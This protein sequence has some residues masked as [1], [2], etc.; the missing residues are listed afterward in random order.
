MSS[1]INNN[2]VDPSV[3]E[4]FNTVVDGGYCIG[5]GACASIPQSPIRMK[6]DKYSM[7]K[8]TIEPNLANDLIGFDIQKVCP[9]SNR[10]RNET[11]IGRDLFGETATQNN[12]IG[13][14]LSTYAGYVSEGSFRKNG[15]SG[16]MGSWLASSLLRHSYVDSVIH[17]HQRQPSEDDKRLFHYQLSTS[18]QE[19]CKSSKSR[20]Y[21]IELSE[22]LSLIRSRPGKYAIVGIPCFIKAIRLLSENDQTIRERVIFCI[23]LVCG[24]LKSTRFAEMFSW[25][26][27]VNPNELTEIDF[28]TKLDGFGANQYGITVSALSN[29]KTIRKVSPPINEMYGS[30]WGQ[31]FF[32]YKACDYCDDVVAETA[33]VTIGDAWLPQYLNDSQ[34]T[35]I[36]VI[37]NPII[38]KIIDEAVSRNA[39]VLDVISPEEVVKSQ[40]SGFAHRREGLAYRLLR[41]DKNSKWRPNKRTSPAVDDGKID[42]KQ[43]Y[44]IQMAE[45]SHSA[46]NEALEANSFKRFVQLMNP[47]LKKYNKLYRPTLWLRVTTKIRQV[48]TKLSLRL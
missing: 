48:R 6:L 24:H 16:G 36:L 43:E 7:F 37:R 38:Q 30:I 44:R 25:Q 23:G 34:G 5:C 47:V 14:Y 28:R 11:E 19:V 10:G 17:V 18:E 3:K 13:Y 27:G 39:L 20:Y 33:D 29:G 1:L 40:S 45:L 9:F 31:G 4:L 41:A 26:C 15:S 46:F 2:P 42:L 8:A 12:K 35:N 32:K 21:P 22:M